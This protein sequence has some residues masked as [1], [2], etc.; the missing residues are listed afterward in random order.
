M[1]TERVVPS[2]PNPVALSSKDHIKSHATP[3][4]AVPSHATPLQTVPSQAIPSQPVQAQPSIPAPQP[5]H[6]VQERE[7]TSPLIAE[8]ELPVH[9][10]AGIPESNYIPPTIHNFAAPAD[11]TSNKDKEPAYKTFALIQNPKVADTVYERSM[12]APSVTISPED[13]LSLSPEIWQR[14]CDAVTPKQ[15]ITSD[16][17]ESQTLATH[18]NSEVPLPFVGEVIDPGPVHTGHGIPPPAGIIPKDHTLL[19]SAIIIPDPY[20]MYLNSLEPGTQPDVLTVT[21]E[22]HALQSLMMLINNQTHVESIINP[23]SQIIT[24]LDAVCH[25]LG[26]HYDPRIQLNMQSVNGIIDK[27]LSLAC[28]IPCRISDI[29]LYLQ[30]HVICD[31]TYDILMGRP[32]DVLTQSIIRNYV[33]K[34]QTITIHNPN[35]GEVTTIPTIPRGHHKH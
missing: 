26:L 23:G 18:Y 13:L 11:K 25:N 33:N 30:I 5:V 28:N 1:R 22:L 8:K 24:M 31:P 21:K 27:S 16:V 2:E 6:I 35:S 14:M 15:V 34:D 10:F 9:P 12:K 20:E 32:F 29:T 17:T 3:S 4:H 19:P 7:N